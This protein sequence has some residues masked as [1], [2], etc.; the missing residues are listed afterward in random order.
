VLSYIMQRNNMPCPHIF[1]GNNLAF[2]PVGPFFRRVGAFFVRRSFSGAVF[3]AKVFSEYIR[4]LL[5]QGFN[6]EVFIEGTR[7][8][9]GKLLLPKL[10]MLSIILN[11]VHE[12][13]CEHLTFVPDLYR[14]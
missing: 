3:Y 10:G 8:R 11:A 13:A 5:G 2:W 1:A 12:G 6:V 14:L 9:N 7:S 4:M